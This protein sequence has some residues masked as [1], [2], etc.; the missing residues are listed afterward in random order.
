[1]CRRR[2]HS[3]FRAALQQPE[4][5][6]KPVVKQNRLGFSARSVGESCRER[7]TQSD[8]LVQE[9]AQEQELHTKQHRHNIKSLV[10]HPLTLLFKVLLSDCQ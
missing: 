6:D 9:H 1:M 5:A 2:T 10:K 8:V 3:V 4:A 7:I